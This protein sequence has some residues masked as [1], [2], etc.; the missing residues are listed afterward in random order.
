MF[1]FYRQAL[2]IGRR[3]QFF[4]DKEY[5]EQTTNLWE[6]KGAVKFIDETQIRWH[7]S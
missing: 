6:W 5:K 2:L 4:K 3:C 1:D 7:Y